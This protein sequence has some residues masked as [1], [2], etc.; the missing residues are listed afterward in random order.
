MFIWQY[1]DIPDQVVKRFQQAYLEN[2][3]NNDLFIQNVDIKLTKF[4]DIDILH[5]ALVQVPPM[6]GINDDG[7][8]I[9][10]HG[11]DQKLALNIP[12]QNCENTTTRFWKSNK[13][14]EAHYTVNGLPYDYFNSEDCE[15]I[16]ETRLVKPFIFNIS[17]PH[18]VTNPQHVWRRS[19][20]LRFKKDPWHFVQDKIKNGRASQLV[21]A[22]VLKTVER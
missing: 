11:P 4:L 16:G 2:L 17:I 19:I 10:V 3:P 18:S 21:M 12:L 20:S 6:A 13:T 15:L 8:H 14:P 5:A 7:I 9:D 22:P 1:I